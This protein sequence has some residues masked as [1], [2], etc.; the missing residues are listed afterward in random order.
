[1]GPLVSSVHTGNAA[2]GGFPTHKLAGKILVL[3][4]VC[5]SN[6]LLL[7]HCLQVVCRSV[8]S[9]TSGG[10]K[11]STTPLAHLKKFAVPATSSSSMVMG[12]RLIASPIAHVQTGGGSGTETSTNA[13]AKL[14]VATNL[15]EQDFLRLPQDENPVPPSAKGTMLCFVLLGS[16]RVRSSSTLHIYPLIPMN[17]NVHR[18]KR[19]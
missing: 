3:V 2:S 13:T 16:M 10:L 14:Q 1:M 8:M 9:L 6:H 18:C 5:H 12:P 4:E 19:S 17:V 7:S 11:P 15:L